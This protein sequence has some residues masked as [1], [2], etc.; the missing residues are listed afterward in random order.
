MQNVS[1]AAMPGPARGAL[2]RGQRHQRRVDGQRREGLAREPDGLRSLHGRDDRDPRGEMAHHLAKARLCR[3]SPVPAPCTCGGPPS[4]SPAASSPSPCP[5][6]IRPLVAIGPAPPRP[7]SSS[8]GSPAPRGQGRPR[9]IVNP[10]LAASTPS[11]RRAASVAWASTSMR[12]DVVVGV[13]GIVVEQGH[14][15]GPGL[16]RDVH[17]VPDRGV[18]PRGLGPELLLGV[19]G[20]VDD[21]VRSVAQ[22]EHGRRRPRRGRR[23]PGDRTRRP[24]PGPRPRSGTRASSRR[25]AP[26]GRAPWPTPP[27]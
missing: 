24:R 25:A 21:Q 18:P 8:T 19:L 27:R 1:A 6:P 26:R 22:L 10:S 23:A 9:S 2:A 7:S 14:V 16:G 20:V 15:P 3:I 11:R 12:V 13:A 17:G 4:A 5:S